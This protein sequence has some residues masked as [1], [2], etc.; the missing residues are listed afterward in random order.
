MIT[1]MSEIAGRNAMQGGGKTLSENG[2][3]QTDM[4]QNSKSELALH[5]FPEE[6]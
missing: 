1:T 6:D 2:Q 5:T 3:T 4:T